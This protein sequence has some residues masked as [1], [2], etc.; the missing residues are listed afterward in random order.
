VEFREI[1]LG[2]L[3]LLTSWLI[4]L[5][6]MSSKD[7]K[8]KRFIE[9]V[10]RVFLILLVFCFHSTGL[11]SFYFFFESVLIPIFVLVLG[12]GYQPERLRAAI[13]I[14]FYTL[15]A[16]LPLLVTILIF[17]SETNSR[18]I[19][20]EALKFREWGGVAAVLIRMAAFIVKF[21]IFIFHLWLPKA[22][23]EAPVSGSMILAGV[24]LKLG[25]VGVF[26]F[27]GFFC[28]SEMASFFFRRLGMVGG[29]IISLII[30]RVVDIKVAIAY[31]SV[32]HIRIVIA[33]FLGNR[34]VGLAGGLWIIISHGLASSGMFSGANIFYERTHSRRMIN[35]KGGLRIS[36]A[37]AL[38]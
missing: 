31:S 10:F 29:G 12:W 17:Q 26:L 3:V 13:Y 32:V 16:S 5:M 6:W 4:I 8:R 34:V 15:A 21:P 9:I 36:G 23:V 33:R 11:I 38:L 14:F 7:P 25:G 27:S 19:I 18:R 28:S 1:I 22:H 20:I 30:L 24:L 35:N 2:L 37:L